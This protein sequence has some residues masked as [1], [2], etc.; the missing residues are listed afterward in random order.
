MRLG[1]SWDTKSKLCGEG[2]SKGIYSRA[3]EDNTS[4]MD[5][6]SESK[7]KEINL[8]PPPFLRYV[9]TC[10]S[11]SNLIP[12]SS[13]LSIFPLFANFHLPCPPKN[14]PPRGH[15]NASHTRKT[16]PRGGE[17]SQTVFFVQRKK[18]KPTKPN[19]STARSEIW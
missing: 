4:P 6:G 9:P 16:P 14:A 5:R 10:L 18:T 17:I 13:R 15:E 19:R 1:W 8:I 2:G 12:F 3:W 7:R 11:P